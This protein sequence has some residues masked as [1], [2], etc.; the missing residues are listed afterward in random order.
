MSNVSDIKP[1]FREDIARTLMSIYF[2]SAANNSQRTTE[3]E[4]YRVGFAAA[5]SSVA[6]AVGV[7]PESFLAPED[8]QRL[9]STSR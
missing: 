1:W 4:N 7:N 6:L 8:I 9:R 2:A 5:L 3:N